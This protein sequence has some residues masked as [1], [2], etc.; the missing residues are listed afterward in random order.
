M[1]Q[2][3]SAFLVGVALLSLFVGSAL[4][5]RSGVHPGQGDFAVYVSPSII[6]T[7]APCPWITI[8]TD[9]PASCVATCSVMVDEDAVPIAD[10]YADSLGNL[11]VKIRF[12]DVAGLVEAPSAV[13]TVDLGNVG[14]ASDTVVVKD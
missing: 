3:A 6:V 9:V 5:N 1:K 12:D 4:C 13:F 8:H 11:V 10:L 14:A 7:S 2:V